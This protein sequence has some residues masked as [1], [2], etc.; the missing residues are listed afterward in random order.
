MGD[1]R[2]HKNDKLKSENP[3]MTPHHFAPLGVIRPNVTFF[4]VSFIYQKDEP[5]ID[6]QKLAQILTPSI[7][8]ISTSARYIRFDDI[9]KE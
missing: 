3:N 2:G 5:S 9:I 8:C 4:E 6:F 1:W 7:T